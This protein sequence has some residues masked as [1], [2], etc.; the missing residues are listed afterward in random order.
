[1]SQPKAPAATA[2]KKAPAAKAAPAAASDGELTPAKPEGYEPVG[3]VRVIAEKGGVRV[4]A[5][6]VRVWKE[7]VAG[8]SEIAA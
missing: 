5:D 2:A 8:K 6:D 7:R 3:D 4:V 1:M